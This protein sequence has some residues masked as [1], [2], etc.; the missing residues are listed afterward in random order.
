MRC[1]ILFLIFII[2]SYSLLSLPSLK[3][4]TTDWDFSFGL[5]RTISKNNFQK[6]WDTSFY[7][8]EL[9]L[10]IPYHWMK[11][12]FGVNFCKYTAK[13]EDISDFYKYFIFSRILYNFKIKEYL[14]VEAG[15]VIGNNYMIFTE[16]KSNPVKYE[17]ELGIGIKADWIIIIKES[18]L[19]SPGIEFQK[20]FTFTKYT[21][22]IL[23]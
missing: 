22:V 15:I 5:R 13:K 6:F 21:S 19:I 4:D 10:G 16:E 17:S 8:P 14:E 7:Q 9:S 1:K 3:A 20:I 11:A 2:Y 23:V 12:E 18:I